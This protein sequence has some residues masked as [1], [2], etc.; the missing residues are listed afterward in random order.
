MSQSALLFAILCLIGLEVNH[1]KWI[2]WTQWDC[3]KHARKHSEWG[4]GAK[5]LLWL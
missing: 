4:C 3:A 1:L 2:W 5:W